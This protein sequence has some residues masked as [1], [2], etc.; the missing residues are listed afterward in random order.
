MLIVIRVK[1]IEGRRAIAK[2]MMR[3]RMRRM[4]AML[5]ELRRMMGL[6]VRKGMAI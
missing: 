1:G 6:K 3:K 2:L 4:V 5:E